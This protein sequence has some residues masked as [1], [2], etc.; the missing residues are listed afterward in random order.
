M[1]LPLPLLTHRLSSFE[2]ESSVLL[3]HR[4][5]NNIYLYRAMDECAQ[6]GI[7]CMSRTRASVSPDPLVAFWSLLPYNHCS[8]LFVAHITETSPVDSSLNRLNCHMIS[9][10][11]TAIRCGLYDQFRGSL[12]L[13]HGAKYLPLYFN[14]SR[15]V[16]ACKGVC[17]ATFVGY[18]IGLLDIRLIA[19]VCTRIFD[20]MRPVFLLTMKIFRLISPSSLPR[21]LRGGYSPTYFGDITA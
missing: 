11:S 10:S 4:N 12:S 21:R 18:I 1:I 16:A 6:T 20:S 7:H 2:H 13:A 3:C 15:D 14:A 17:A 19:D 8:R 5:K 9:L